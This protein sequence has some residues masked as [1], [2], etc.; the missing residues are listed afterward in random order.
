MIIIT[1]SLSSPVLSF[2]VPSRLSFLTIAG[3][4]LGT[5]F[6]LNPMT[7]EARAKGLEIVGF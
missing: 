5:F 3:F 1:C 2:S 7:R 6:F 4:V